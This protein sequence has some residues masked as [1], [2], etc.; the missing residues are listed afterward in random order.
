[1]SSVTVLN[2][3]EPNLLNVPDYIKDLMSAYLPIFEKQ[4]NILIAK[5]ELFLGLIEN[6]DINLGGSSVPGDPGSQDAQVVPNA[7]QLA[8]PL[9]FGNCPVPQ[10]WD[11]AC[12]RDRNKVVTDK[13]A[14]ALCPPILNA[15][16]GNEKKSHLIAMLM[17][18]SASAK[19]LQRCVISVYKELGDLPLYFE[20]YQ[21]SI[22]DYKHRNNAIPLMPLSQV[23]IF[24]F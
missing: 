14:S 5:I 18:L 3:A 22:A 15:N 11:R 10:I 4:L 2:F 21:N 13:V 20:T 12:A 7:A 9:G 17:H 24:S 6:T 16:N 19:S 1:M 23:S 8:A